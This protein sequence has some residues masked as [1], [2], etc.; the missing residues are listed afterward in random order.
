MSDKKNQFELEDDTE[1]KKRSREIQILVNPIEPDPQLQPYFLSDGA[2]VFEVSMDLSEVIKQR[3]ESYFGKPFTIPLDQPLW[4]L[5]DQLRRCTPDGPTIGLPSHSKT[6]RKIFD[7][8]T[9][10]LRVY[11]KRC[12]RMRWPCEGS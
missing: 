3:L 5:V 9:P 2:T 1:T 11:C 10:M 6:R 8:L 7:G 4:K 12:V